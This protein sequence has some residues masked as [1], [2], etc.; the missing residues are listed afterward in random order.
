MDSAT[1]SSEN[2]ISNSV[3]RVHSISLCF[4]FIHTWKPNQ[5]RW[6]QPCS[7]YFNCPR[8]D[9]SM[10]RCLFRMHVCMCWTW[11]IPLTWNAV[12]VLEKMAFKEKSI[13]KIFQWLSWLLHVDHALFLSIRIT[14]ATIIFPQI[15]SSIIRHRSQQKPKMC[16]VHSTVA[17]VFTDFQVWAG[18]LFGFSQID[19]D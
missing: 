1:P 5:M 7:D 18:T 6:Y 11:S 12:I 9:K 16:I 17:F 4:T 3:V 13:K 14:N 2:S 8:I 10:I 15:K 19:C